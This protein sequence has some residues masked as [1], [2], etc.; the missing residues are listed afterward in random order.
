M[1]QHN[2]AIKQVV[3]EIMADEMNQFYTQEGIEPLF[4]APSTAKILLVGQAP[5]RLAQ[6]SRQ[7]F[8]D[9]SGDRLRSWLGV[10]REVFYESG[11]F[12][13][14]PM[15]FYFPGKG[16]SG[17]KP[18]RKGFAEKWH[19]QLLELMPDVELIILIGAY[20]QKYYLGNHRKRTLTETVRHYQEY[21]PKFLPL[22]HPSPLNIGWMKRNP[23]F[24]EE[25]IPELQ[26]RVKE[27]V[28]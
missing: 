17:D 25:V 26:H 3:Q 16:K 13:I 28:E 9:P 19:P 22:V 8:N 4:V 27:I 14:V 1:Y 5:G 20:S 18:P 7:T 23:W 10:N 11:K 12:G 2:H 15:D 21:L 24:E 6:E